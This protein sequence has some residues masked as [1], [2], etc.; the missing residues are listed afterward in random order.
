MTTTTRHRTVRGR[1]AARCGVS[2]PLL[3]D[4]DGDGVGIRCM[5]DRLDHLTH[6][7]STA[8]G[9]IRATRR[10]ARTWVHVADYVDI[11]PVRRLVA[12]HAEPG[13]RPRSASADGPGAQPLL[14]GARVVRRGAGRATGLTGAG[15]FHL[16]DRTRRRYTASQQLAVRIRR[17]RLD[18][19]RR[20][21]PVVSAQLR[22]PP[23]RLQ[24][25]QSGGRV[26]EKVL[27]FWPTVVSTESARRHTCYSAR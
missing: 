11:D 20:H 9:S 21:R 18:P 10:P 22:R 13:P 16:P 2:G 6:S 15:T 5:S 14:D 25:A 26:L 4:S 23:A 24:L 8:R 7:G 1:D 17:T 3:A 27:R 12:R 19:R